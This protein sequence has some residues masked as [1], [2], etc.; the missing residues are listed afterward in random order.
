MKATM[1]T[2]TT[3]KPW[4]K[5]R[6]VGKIPLKLK[7]IWAVRAWLKLSNDIRIGLDLTAYRIHTMRRTKA[8]LIYQSRK[9]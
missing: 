9:N 5:G 7:D 8:S 6:L 2:A 1:H 4:N 3:H